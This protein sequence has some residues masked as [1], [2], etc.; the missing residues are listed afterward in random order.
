MR[1]ARVLAG[2]LGVFLG[3]LLVAS[4]GVFLVINLLP[5]DVAHVILGSSATPES[6]ARLQAQM[7]LDRPVLLRYLAWL[8]GCLHGNLGASAFT[9][10]PVGGLIAQRL[11]V[12]FSL[13][14][15]GMVL[16]VAAA[17]PAGIFAALRRRSRRGQLVLAASQIGMAVP[18]FLAGIALVM[19]FAVALRW[20]PANGYVPLTEDPWGWAQRLVLP[21]IALAFVQAAV[22][23]RYVRGAFLDVLGE[24]YLRTARSIGWQARKALWRHGWRNAAIQLVTVLG[25][26]VGA[27]FAGAVV[28]ENVFVLPGVG[29]LLLRSVVTRDLPIV[30]AIVVVLVA[31]VLAVN[32]VVDVA[33]VVIDPRLR[34]GAEGVAE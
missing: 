28:V 8:G 3:S 11:G 21:W 26:Q 34:L 23:V 14:A 20:L 29:S 17:L 15:G 7:G 16:A 12:T 5:G 2:R 13:V 24:D 10:A 31:L 27:L 22:L 19:C 4:L 18:V 1:L 30:Q 32:L 6:V 33:Y 9:G 25:L